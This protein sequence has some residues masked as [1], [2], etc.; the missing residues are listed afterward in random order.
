M[1]QF[2][3]YIIWLFRYKK[4]KEYYKLWEKETKQDISLCEDIIN[5]MKLCN[6]FEELD[7]LIN[8]FDITI[9]HFQQSNAMA[10]EVL[11]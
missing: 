11:K 9:S 8:K 10:R 4:F 2:L 5:Q 3:K 6:S 1:I 7:Q